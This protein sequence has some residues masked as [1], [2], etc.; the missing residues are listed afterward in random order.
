MSKL[1]STEGIVL[2]S[3][4]VDVHQFISRCLIP[5]DSCGK[6]G[7]INLKARKLSVHA[8]IYIQ[9]HG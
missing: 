3:I 7:R 6:H 9:R 2:C 5:L 8:F 1:L 4:I